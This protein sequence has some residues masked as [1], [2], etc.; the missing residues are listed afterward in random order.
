[1]F[2]TFM[3]DLYRHAKMNGIPVNGLSTSKNQD[4]NYI[5]NYIQS[6]NTIYLSTSN[7]STSYSNSGGGTHQINPNNM[8][9]SDTREYC[10]R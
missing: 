5:Y 3:E 8:S 9:L 4:C 2:Y 6:D 10:S 7:S 1:M